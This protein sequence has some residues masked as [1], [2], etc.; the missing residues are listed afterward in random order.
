MVE[1]DWKSSMQQTF[2]FFKVNPITWRDDVKLKNFKDASIIIDSTN[3][4]ISYATFNG[5]NINGEMYVRIYMIAIQ[6][7]R[8][9]RIP[10]GTF[11]IQTSS[12]LF[13]GKVKD[14]SIDAYSPLTELKE[15]YPP[16]GFYIPND[17][18]LMM[19]AAEYTRQNLRAP[20]VQGDVSSK[21][22]STG[23]VFVAGFDDDWLTFLSDLLNGA[24]FRF[25]I[26]PLGRIG[27]APEQ[28]AESLTPVWTYDDDNSSILYPEI[29][30][31][32]DLYGIPNVVEV[33][34][35]TS[36]DFYLATARNEDKNSPTSIPSRGREIVHRVTS[37]D[38]LMTRSQLDDYAKNLLKTLSSIE[39]TLSY[40]H[41]Y[42]PVRVG[43]CVMLN[44]E[45]AGLSGIKATVMSQSIECKSGCSVSE[46]AKFTKNLWG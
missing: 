8:T 11:L 19:S 9:F 39:Y 10:L 38:L 35:S 36:S 16:I 32:R 46:T 27:F 41:G 7:R 2:E 44:Y 34:Y 33:L 22:E 17:E 3:E 25:D 43:D 13:N 31:D 29:S 1:I 40:K 37:P 12:E 4:T 18:N 5:D 45:R 26:D 14:N 30:V 28:D 42:C 20:V 15:K 23:M 6:N 24:G 21:V